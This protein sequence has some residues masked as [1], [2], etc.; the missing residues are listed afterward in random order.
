M[1]IVRSEIIFEYALIGWQNKSYDNK[2]T[3]LLPL[4]GMT[5]TEHVPPDCEELMC[6]LVSYH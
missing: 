1:I 6:L 5:A 4:T 3:R 2:G